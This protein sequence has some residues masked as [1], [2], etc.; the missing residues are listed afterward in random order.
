MVGA[1]ARRCRG[2][3]AAPP[4]DASSSTVDDASSRKRSPASGGSSSHRQRRGKERCH[5][6]VTLRR[7]RPDRR[8]LIR[9]YSSPG[10]SDLEPRLRLPA[11][12]PGRSFG[13]R[14][15]PRSRGR[16]RRAA[17]H[18]DPLHCVVRRVS[19]HLVGKLAD[20][21]DQ[22]LA[23]LPQQPSI[24]NDLLGVLVGL[25][26][27]RSASSWHVAHGRRPGRAR[28]EVDLVRRSR[29]RAG[30]C[31]RFRRRPR[32]ALC[33]TPSRVWWTS[34]RPRALERR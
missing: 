5:L 1:V 27:S 7:T 2:F 10:S 15:R 20:V 25:T 32:R 31:S 21:F 29:A 9:P 26:L 11:P 33:T 14:G 17:R 34:G 16:R 18:L 8:L 13:P 30:G 4:E 22:S 19:Q 24:D 28:R 12:R 6:A 3:F 23:F